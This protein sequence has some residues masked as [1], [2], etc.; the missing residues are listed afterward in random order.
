MRQHFTYTVR[1][2]SKTMNFQV[3]LFILKNICNNFLKPSFVRWPRF[4]VLRYSRGNWKTANKGKRLNL[5]K[6]EK[7]QKNH[8][9]WR[10]RTVERFQITHGQM[11]LNVRTA[12]PP[13]L[14]WLDHFFF[15]WN[16]QLSI[17]M[18][19]LARWQDPFFLFWVLI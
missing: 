8:V 5:L 6:S 16:F 17:L 3:F 12:N 9:F 13:L 11:R 4:V 19:F 1:E 7:H 14:T 10:C 2:K 18:N 15:L